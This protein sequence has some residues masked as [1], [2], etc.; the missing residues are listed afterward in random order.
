MQSLAQ[1]TLFRHVTWQLP[2]GQSIAKALNVGPL[3]PDDLQD[4][5]DIYAPFGNHTPLFLYILREAELATGGH[6]LGPVGGRIVTEVFL[7]LLELDPR[8]YLSQEPTWR[9]HLGAVGHT[10]RYDMTSFLR[11][12]GVAGIR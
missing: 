2:S 9:P 7:A 5:R 1:R 6:H 3:R 8:G 11:Y 4:L 10:G 12:A